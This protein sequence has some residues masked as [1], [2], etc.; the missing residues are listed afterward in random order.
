MHQPKLVAIATNYNWFEVPLQS[1]QDKRK[2]IKKTIVKYLKRLWGKSI[3]DDC[4]SLYHCQ[5]LDCILQKKEFFYLKWEAQKIS[6]CD[7][8]LSGHETYIRDPEDF[9]RTCPS[10]VVDVDLHELTNAIPK[11][12]TV[13]NFKK[14]QTFCRKLWMILWARDKT[15][16][17]GIEALRIT[18][19]ILFSK[20]LG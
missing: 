8:I 7:L 9:I 5:N 10:P 20:V 1:L 12:E 13:P 14:I 17:S 2:S 4:S 3:Y 19:E 15:A 16:F 18:K 11:C 6:V